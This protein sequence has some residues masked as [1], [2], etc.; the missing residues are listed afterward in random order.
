MADKK[1]PP[2]LGTP[3]LVWGAPSESYRW[4]K[5]AYTGEGR[6]G[7]KKEKVDME[8]LMRDPHVHVELDVEKNEVLPDGDLQGFLARRLD[9]KKVLEDFDMVV[10]A[11]K[12]L[13][14]LD[15]IKF[16]N[17]VEIRVDRE[18]IYSHPEKENDVRET[19]LM[20]VD[21]GD[22]WEM[23]KSIR[24]RAV[25][26]ENHRAEI[27]IKRIHRK[28]EN[29]IDVQFEGNIEKRR[30][31]QFINYLEKNLEVLDVTE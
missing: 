10:T 4:A 6:G 29:A 16:K 1:E 3:P 21:L 18:I 14:A 27:R 2:S 30:F 25:R 20:L 24:I 5:I 26:D 31:R 28:T 8:E 15:N 23:A 11:E 13:R 12:F 17:V 7:D 22:R 19:I 9:R